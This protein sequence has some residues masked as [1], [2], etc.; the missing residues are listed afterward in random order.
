MVNNTPAKAHI[1]IRFFLLLA[2]ITVVVAITSTHQP[3]SMPEIDPYEVVDIMIDAGFG[4]SGGETD[5]GLLESRTIVITTD[6]NPITAQKVIKSLL[7]LDASDETQPIDLY[8]RTEGGWISDAFA[9]IDV[10]Q[11][12][13][14]PVNTHAIGGAYSSG[15]M[16][17][18]AGTG[19]RYGHPNC[20]IMFHAG[21]YE[22]NSPFSNDKVD[23]DRLL[24]FWKTHSRMPHDW[25]TQEKEKEYYL[26]QEEALQY[27]I[28]DQI[29]SSNN[30]PTDFSIVTE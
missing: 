5:P 13:S 29:R 26:T 28:I 30:S 24:H 4:I 15:A 25:L 11:H 16:L 21:L 22:D 20:C 6:I 19:T 12:I 9:I 14:A 8:V 27:G 3:Q 18:A 17:V 7:L 10:M 2:T 23:N 1:L